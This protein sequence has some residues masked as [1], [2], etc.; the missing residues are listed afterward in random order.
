MARQYA[1]A[2]FTD[3][4]NATQNTALAW[5]YAGYADHFLQDSFAA[6]HL[7][8][9]TLAMQWF[10]E[11]VSATSVPVDNWDLIKDF[12]SAAQPGLAGTGLYDLSK[13]LVSNDP[14]TVEEYADY[15]QRMAA[16]GLTP[17][18]DANYQR[19]LAFLGSMAAQL[20]SGAV[21]DHFNTKSVYVASAGHPARYQLWGD[22][23]MLNGA[24]GAGAAQD[25]AR[26]SQAAIQE[27]ISAGHT[28]ITQQSLLDSLPTQVSSTA[29]GALQPIET[30]A[31]SIAATSKSEI[32]GYVRSAAA[33]GLSPRI[34]RV[35]QDWVGRTASHEVWRHSLGD[36][37]AWDNGYGRNVSVLVSGE[38]LYATTPGY[39]FQLDKATGANPAGY[40]LLKGYD[41]GDVRLAG[42][43]ARVYAG[44]T[45]WL[46]AISTQNLQEILWYNPLSGSGN[47][48]TVN[49]I[50][51]LPSDPSSR[52]MD[53][54]DLAVPFV[55]HNGH[56][57][58]VNPRNGATNS[59]LELGW[60]S[61]EILVA[62]DGDRLLVGGNGGVT[63]LVPESGPPFAYYATWPR[64]V[65][66]GT[67]DQGGRTNVLCEPGLV[68]ASAWKF[69]TKFDPDTGNVLRRTELR[70]DALELRLATDGVNV[71]AASTGGTVYGI[72]DGTGEQLFKL[73][74]NTPAQAPTTLLSRTACCTRPPGEG[75]PPSTQ[76][77]G[78]SY[79][80]QSSTRPSTPA[81]R[82]RSRRCEWIPME[83]PSSWARTCGWWRSRWRSKGRCGPARG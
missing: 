18:V 61:Y 69:L 54:A 42:D 46:P 58:S 83:K 29:T 15:G 63:A 66:V 64:R 35:S 76:T 45:G 5:Q 37:P 17:A 24:D 20:A 25:A 6:G 78:R 75:S 44:I 9:K 80:R 81:A 62:S 33:W 70:S 27:L 40:N 79:S 71:F 41:Y 21:H 30:W 73:E 72:D 82:R 74:M 3:P 38:S 50:L 39:V 12:T 51:V 22:D 65:L 23:T 31:R 59:Y 32:F 28:D 67:G 53:P 2:A 56:V 13:Q 11:W 8:N 60:G 48:L 43:H 68:Y 47:T 1:T 57:Y 14:Q 49:P 55:G 19:Y 52:A 77:A 26:R 34:S 10:I 16:V 4:A 7:I 36:W